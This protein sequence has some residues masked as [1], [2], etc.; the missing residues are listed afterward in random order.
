MFR[1]RVSYGFDEPSL[2]HNVVS[3]GQDGVGASIV[4]AKLV[5]VP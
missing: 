3:F 5:M 1:A 4:G 2:S